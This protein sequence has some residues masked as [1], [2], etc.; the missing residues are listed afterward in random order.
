MKKYSK[1]ICS[2]VYNTVFCQSH[3]P[4]NKPGD[5]YSGGGGNLNWTNFKLLQGSFTGGR[6]IYEVVNI[7]NI[8]NPTYGMHQVGDI[9]L[10]SDCKYIVVTG[11]VSGLNVSATKEV[12]N[13][14]SAW[15]WCED[16]NG[17]WEIRSE[18]KNKMSCY[19]SLD[20]IPD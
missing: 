3:Y 11:C 7:E 5:E 2:E 15:F 17:N 4:G 18:Y 14:S 13:P 20:V 16:G 1:P 6:C 19:S 12:D 8:S 10:E 9:A